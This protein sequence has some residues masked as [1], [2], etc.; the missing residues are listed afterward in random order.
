MSNDQH[1]I[2]ACLPDKSEHRSIPEYQSHSFNETTTA[3]AEG[4]TLLYSKMYL[5]R[6]LIFSTMLKANMCFVAFLLL[7]FPQ[8]L[9]IQDPNT[10]A[11]KGT[12][13]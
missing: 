2:F 10:E 7:K 9:K 13:K 11:K 3:S 12:F 6:V 1:A 5:S 8:P 4:T